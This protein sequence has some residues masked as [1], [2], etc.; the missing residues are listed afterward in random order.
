MNNESS[1]LQK[2]QEKPL[3][4]RSGRL[5]KL[6]RDI[7]DMEILKAA[8][9]G[10]LLSREPGEEDLDACELLRRRYSAGPV[11]PTCIT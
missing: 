5:L 7:T 2:Y 3:R 10:Q 4:G 11:S 6:Y 8:I 1:F 9:R